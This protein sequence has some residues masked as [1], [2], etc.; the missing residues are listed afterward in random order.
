MEG[1]N[2]NKS[3]VYYCL[4]IKSL[5]YS[6]FIQTGMDGYFL[7]KQ[8]LNYPPEMTKINLCLRHFTDCLKINGPYCL[9]C[10]TQLDWLS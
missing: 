5:K 2:T 1:F 7:G 9:T 10:N 8:P 3:F 4:I 6:H